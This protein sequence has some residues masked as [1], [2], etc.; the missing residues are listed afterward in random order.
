M[1]CENPKISLHEAPILDRWEEAYFEIRV[2]KNECKKYLL[3]PSKEGIYE[4]DFFVEEWAILHASAI[5]IWADMV[6]KMTIS[7]E[8]NESEGHLN[9]L[10]LAQN[11]SNLE[12]SGIGKV[13]PWCQNVKL[14]V[15]QTN[16][17][18]GSWAKIRGIPVLEV[19]TDSIE[20]GHSCRI[21]RVSDEA[22]FYLEAHGLSRET[23][24]WLL[25]EAEIWRHVAVMEEWA[26]EIKT[27]ILE[28]INPTFREKN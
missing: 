27:T 22:M 24:E 4:R 20:W 2:R 1:K 13:R 3:F 12:L 28:E 17:L 6:L 16:I 9:I 14:R 25:L 10:G 15:D 11:N 26:E 23:A 8:W 19:A 21:H 18:L 7:M 5:S